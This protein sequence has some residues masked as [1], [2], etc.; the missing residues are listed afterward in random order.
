MFAQPTTGLIA[1]YS[2]DN[3]DA[4]DDTGNG[5]NGVIFGN[6]SCECGVQGQALQ[7]DGIDDYVSFQGRIND[8]FALGNFTISFYYKSF[9]TGIAHDILSKREACDN[10]AMFNIEYINNLNFISTD[11]I[12]NVSNNAFISANTP[13]TCWQHYVL[14]RDD[15]TLSLYI[16]GELKSQITSNNTIN[17]TN[18]ANLTIGNSPCINTTI[19]R[20][21]G[22]IDE[23]RI[24]NLALLPEGIDLL[25]SRPDHIGNRDTIIFLG[26]SLETFTTQ[27]C[28][29]NF[30]W[31]PTDFVENPTE[32][33]TTITPDFSMTYT[34]SFTDDNFCTTVDTL[35]VKVIDPDTLDCREVFLPKAFTPNG[36]ELNDVYGI[37][38]PQVVPNLIAFEIYD[39]WG[40]RVFATDSAFDTWDGSFLGQP[41]NAGVFV[42]RLEFSCNSEVISQTGTITMIR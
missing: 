18:S 10:N 41:L 30:E 20:F 8:L 31:S 36:D 35:N 34:L 11:L 6:P 27:T 17:L 16:N 37:S 23:L 42:Y 39:R 26:N 7:F 25:Y 38:N 5:S 21:R 33:N 12:E 13:A 15:R 32:P 9:D 28:V 4:A 2:F 19:A 22:M 24:Y 29:T 1:Y 40:S 3:C 14:T